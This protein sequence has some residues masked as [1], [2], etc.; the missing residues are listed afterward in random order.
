MGDTLNEEARPEK[1]LGILTRKFVEL[2]ISS[3]QGILDLKQVYVEIILLNDKNV[4]ISFFCIFFWEMQAAI[5]LNITQKRRI[6]D[7]TNVLE[8]VGLIK[9][10]NKNSV[11][12]L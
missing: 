3:D 2:M 6:Y 11:Q 8:G 9:K 1:S 12:W 7:I 10:A 5:Q 4:N